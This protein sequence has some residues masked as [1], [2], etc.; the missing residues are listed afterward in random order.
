[1]S[2]TLYDYCLERNGHILLEQWDEEKNGELS[3][4]NVTHGSH[5]KVWWRCEEGHQWDAAVYCRTIDN[6]GCPYCARKKPHPCTHSLASDYPELLP[7]WHPTKNEGLE[8][9]NIAPLSHRKV[10]WICGKGHEWQA[11]VKSRARGT[12]CPYCANKQVRTGEN[13]LATVFPDIAGEWNYEK[14]GTL[15]P[16]SIVYGSGSKMWWRCQRGHEWQATVLSRTLNASAC[17]VCAGRKVIPGENDFASI[18]PKL[19]AQW[20]PTK[21]GN[22]G[23]DEITAF[24]NRKVWWLCDKG[25]EYEAMVSRRAQSLT[26]CPYCANRKVLV[27]FNDL[28]STEPKIAS[29]WHTELNGALTPQ[30]VTRGSMKK[31]WW[32]CSEGHVWKA[33]IYSRAGAQKCGCPVCSGKVKADKQL[34]YED[35]IGAAKIESL[36]E[37]G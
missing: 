35:I 10:W 27:G 29:Q 2:K 37:K 32:Q 15:T 4:R 7:E 19:A 23:P 5:R 33:V 16:Q 9:E 34:K 31:V 17:P 36:T 14:N 25:H 6:T 11:Q 28:A 24:S 8:P 18:F 22:L 13:D 30:M 1:M 26:G 3:P 21:N 12:G 20:H